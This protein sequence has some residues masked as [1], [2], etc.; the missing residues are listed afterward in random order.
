MKKK[1]KITL[2]ERI[3]V[4]KEQLKKIEINHFKILGAIEMLE[5]MKAEGEE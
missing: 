3:D 2:Q 1:E 4:L 5:G